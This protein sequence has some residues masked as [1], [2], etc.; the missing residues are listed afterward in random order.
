MNNETGEMRREKWGRSE[1]RG[2]LLA[3]GGGALGAFL[4][5]GPKT[6]KQSPLI[7]VAP[8]LAWYSDDLLG[9]LGMDYGLLDDLVTQKKLTDRQREVLDRVKEAKAEAQRVLRETDE[10]AIK[11]TTQAE[12]ERRAQAHVLTRDV[13][14]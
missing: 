7:F 12:A 14:V 11:E 10:K 13:A 2:V 1:V 6:G 3:E 4:K 8:R 9:R 5:I